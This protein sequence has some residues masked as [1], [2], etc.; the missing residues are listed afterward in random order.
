MLSNLEK[1]FKSV[2]GY[3]VGVH[4]T[5]Y[6]IDLDMESGV[7]PG[8]IFTVVREGKS[9]I[10]PV[11]K[12][13]IGKLDKTI[14]IAKLTRIK[15]G[16]SF[17]RTIPGGTN[18]IK[19]G[20]RIVRYQDIPA[21]FWDYTDNSE[22]FFYMVKKAIPSLTWMD[23]K[24]A[25]GLKSIL[26]EKLDNNSLSIYFILKDNQL[27]VRDPGFQLIKVY[28]DLSALNIKKHTAKSML[29]QQDSNKIIQADS[30]QPVQKS[31]YS[32]NKGVS[33]NY[34][35]HGTF[36][37]SIVMSDFVRNGNHKFIATTNGKRISIYSFNEKLTLVSEQKK[38]GFDQILDLSWW[39]PNKNS[40][41]YLAV[42]YW[43]NDKIY[44]D[45]LLVKDGNL[46][47]FKKN[48]QY[49]AGSFDLD[50][51]G[52]PETLI[53][54]SFDRERFWGN[55]LKTARLNGNKISYSPLKLKLPNLFTVSGS[56]IADLD[57]DGELESVIV[58]NRRLYIFKEKKMIYKS[59]RVA[60][61]SMSEINY[62]VQG[63]V[64]LIDE[65]SGTME[66]APVLA[67]IKGS[68]ALS[69]ISITAKLSS[70]SF[71]SVSSRI[72]SSQLMMHTYTGKTFVRSVFGNDI[73]NPIQGIAFDNNKLFLIVSDENSQ[74][75]LEGKGHLLSIQLPSS[76]SK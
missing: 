7:S 5:E 66:V 71:G 8:D 25:Q 15:K 38:M 21:V 69:I 70:I 46:L 75:E 64:N 26:P 54:Q 31:V 12:K 76:E 24:Q 4:E 40:P 27:E 50:Q 61:A 59:K 56:V 55:T 63:A 20:D 6:I 68:K 30:G 35:L 36:K 9:I 62:D 3:I 73:E 19:V 16:Y 41:L 58:R 1:D 39:I 22:Y 51:D 48:L 14:A 28:S 52:S 13:I 43:L 45:L 49:F 37:D 10:H 74:S 17:V 67:G 23:F 44:S 18:G 11:T 53:L 57:N 47:P 32:S 60:G 65:M 42:T 72:R 34:Q 29:I 2:S 33:G